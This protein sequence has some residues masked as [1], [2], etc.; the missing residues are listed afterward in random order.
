[1]FAEISAFSTFSSDLLIKLL[2]Q[3]SVPGRVAV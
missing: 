1:M 3:E 2:M